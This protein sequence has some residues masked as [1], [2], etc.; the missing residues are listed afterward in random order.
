[1]VR[2]GD[3]NCFMRSRPSCLAAALLTSGLLMPGQQPSPAS[4]FTSDQAN[5]GRVTYEKTCGR[6]HTLSLLGRKGDPSELPPIGSLS[7]SDKQFI[8][9]KGHVYVPPLAGKDFLDRWGS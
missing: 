4:V 8:G 9:A 7:D 3:T 6:C 5:A 2:C 1:M